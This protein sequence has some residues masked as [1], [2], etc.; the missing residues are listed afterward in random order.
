MWSSRRSIWVKIDEFDTQVEAEKVAKDQ[1]K[2]N[3]RRHRVVS[4]STLFEA[5]DKTK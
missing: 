2:Y 1:I 3:G 4:K 5:G